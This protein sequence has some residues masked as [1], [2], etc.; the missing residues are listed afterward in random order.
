MRKWFEDYFG[1]SRRE[2]NGLAA[3]AVI[4][5][6]LWVGPALFGLWISDKEWN[7]PDK[8]AEIERFLAA[9]VRQQ[10]IP[11][12]EPEYFV[13][14][15]NGLSITDWKRLGLSDWQIKTIKNYEA[16]GGRF[17]KPTD[18]KKIYTISESD[19]NRLE[20]YIRIDKSRRTGT[21]R[22]A[23]P[24]GNADPYSY[25]TT[26]S[27]RKTFAQLKVPIELNSTDSLELQE[28]P[29]IGPVFAS[30]IVRFRDLLGG[31]YGV[32][33]LLDVYGMDSVRY[34]GIKDRVF[35]DTTALRKIPLNS[36][37]YSQLR[38]HPL[39]GGK[40]ANNIIQYRRQH[41]QYQQLSDI[42]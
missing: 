17:W 35:V 27:G 30:R 42:L 22:S 7:E 32:S 26:A 28:L 37:T 40:L 33:Q 4:L 14:D 21:V 13:F 39:I 25:D 5:L 16:K 10:E 29:G 3:L 20:P 36:A 8:I 1:F 6:F 11:P 12:D 9:S 18:V 31:F 15:P 19:Y 24:D 38:R 23:A 2:R 41:G 34:G